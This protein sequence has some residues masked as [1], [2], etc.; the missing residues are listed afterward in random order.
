M[1]TITP[2][3]EKNTFAK[4]VALH[5]TGRTLP[6]GLRTSRKTMSPTWCIF[7]GRGAA[8]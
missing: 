8:C 3:T 2:A 1:E 6:L 5:I 4:P 7:L